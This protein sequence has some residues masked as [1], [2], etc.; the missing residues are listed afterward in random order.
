MQL[1][2]EEIEVIETLTQDH[3]HSYGYEFMSKAEAPPPGAQDLEA[4]AKRSAERR[5]GAWQQLKQSNY[6][7]YVLR[8][9]RV[10]YLS[11]CAELPTRAS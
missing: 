7:D 5:Q 2:P 3:M 10:C 6:R 1:S 11:S 4:C 8:R 9:H